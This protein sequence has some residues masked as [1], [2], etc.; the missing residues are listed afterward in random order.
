MNADMSDYLDGRNGCRDLLDTYKAA[1]HNNIMNNI[2]CKGCP[3]PATRAPPPIAQVHGWTQ[4]YNLLLYTLVQ[5]P[6]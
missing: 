5:V 4:M 2:F 6:L 1:M 3:E